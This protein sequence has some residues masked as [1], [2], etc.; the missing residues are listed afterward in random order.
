MDAY[1]TVAELQ[2]AL[3]KVDAQ[4]LSL[5]SQQHY[6]KSQ[7]ALSEARELALADDADASSVASRGLD[8]LDWSVDHAKLASN[9]FEEVLAARQ[10]A[11]DKGSLDMSSSQLNEVDE[12]FKELTLAYEKGDDSSKAKRPEMIQRYQGLQLSAIKQSTIDQATAVLKQAKEAGAS[13]YASKTYAAAEK[14][15]QMASAVLEADVG[16]QKKAMEHANQSIWE[17]ERSMSITDTVKE[18]D[19]SNF[20][21][22]DIVLWYQQQLVKVT[23][24][25]GQP[26]PLNKANHNLINEAASSVAGVAGQQLEL[27]QALADSEQRYADAMQAK[28]TELSAM[29]MHYTDAALMRSDREKATKESQQ[30]FTDEEAL[31]YMQ[32]DNVLIRAHGF[33][34]QSG[35]SDIDARNFALLKKIEQTIDKFP[36]AKIV[37]SGHTDSTGNDKANMELSELRAENVAKFL[38]DVGGISSDRLS[39]KGYG[40]TKPVES[41][42][43]ATGREANRRVEVLIVNGS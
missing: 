8:D 4:Q 40:R 22:E 42:A 10:Q 35:G 18:F 9:T 16:Q 43:S 23:A 39:S 6:K 30:L 25:T 26:L 20:S 37:V 41:N 7:D 29:E 3:Q 1:P 14:E 36:D 19:Q 28:Q 24:S 17:A 21:N 27:E 38:H 5:M 13:K 32:R 33:W 12:A 34:F 2:S 31:V 15:L 11:I